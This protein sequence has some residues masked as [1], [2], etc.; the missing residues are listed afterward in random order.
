MP[1][2][3]ETTKFNGAKPTPMKNVKKERE[4]KKK[5]DREDEEDAKKMGVRA[6]LKRS[7]PE[8]PI[9]FDDTATHA[10]EMALEVSEYDTATDEEVYAAPW[11]FPSLIRARW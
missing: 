1:R 7:C 10:S 4:R 8:C 11:P 5:L 2:K 6:R 9:C 3:G